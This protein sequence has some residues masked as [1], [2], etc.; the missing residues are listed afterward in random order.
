MSAMAG[1]GVL[2][3]LGSRQKTPLTKAVTTPLD[4][5]LLRKVYVDTGANPAELEDGARF[6]DSKCN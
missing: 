3:A 5:W 2:S 6:A 4:V 1:R